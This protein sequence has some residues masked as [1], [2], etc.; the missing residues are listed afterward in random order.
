M[1]KCFTFATAVCIAGG[2]VFSALGDPYIETDGSQA[3]NTGYFV[4]PKTRV[5][6]DYAMLD[7][8]T[9]QQRVF[10]CLGNVVCQHYINGSRGYSFALQNSS[11]DWLTVRP[12][13]VQIFATADRRRF[14]LDVKN[15]LASFY[16]DG[17]LVT[18]RATKNVTNTANYPLGLFTTCNNAAFTSFADQRGKLRLYSFK[19]YEDDVLVMELLPYRDGSTYCLKDTVSGTLFPPTIGNPFTGGDLDEDDPDTVVIA[20]GYNVMTNGPRV[21][22]TKNVQVNTAGSGGIVKMNPYSGYTGWTRLACGTLWADNLTGGGVG[23]LGGSATLV[24]GPGTLRYDG[25]DG[26]VWSGTITNTTTKLESTVIDTQHDLTLEGKWGWET[27][28]FVKTGPGTLTL[29][30]TAGGNAELARDGTAIEGRHNYQTLNLRANGDAPTVGFGKLTVAEGTLVFGGGNWSLEKSVNGEGTPLLAVVGTKTV[31]PIDN[32]ANAQEKEATL[33][34]DAGTVW[35]RGWFGVGVK[36]GFSTTTPDFVPTSK[37]IINGGTTYITNQLVVGYNSNTI[38]EKD[39]QGKWIPFRTSPRVEV[40]GGTFRVWNQ[41]R[42]CDSPGTDCALFIDGGNLTV[43]HVLDTSGSHIRFASNLSGDPTLPRHADVTVCTNGVLDITAFFINNDRTNVTVNLNVLDGGRFRNNQMRLADTQGRTKNCEMNVL[44]DG[45]ILELRWGGYKDWIKADVTSVRI[46][47][48]GATLRANGCDVNVTDEIHVS[49]AAADTHPDEEAKGVTVSGASNYNSGFRFFLPQYWAGPTRI[50]TN[51]ICEMADT[52]AFPSG[53]DL[54]LDGTGRLVLTNGIAHAVNSFTLGTPNMSD[55]SAL[56]LSPGT[57]IQAGAFGVAGA[58]SLSL[59]L[60]AAAGVTNSLTAAGTYVLMSGPASAEDGLREIARRTAVANPADGTDY[61]LDVSVDGDTASL[62]V[63]VAPGPAAVATTKAWGN[64]QGGNWSEGANW[65]DGAEANGAGA[66]AAFT[67]EAEADG[68]AVTVD[69]AKTVGGLAFSTANA[70]ALSGS[71]L[72]LANGASPATVNVTAGGP[73]IANALS[74]VGSANLNT[75]GGTTLGVSGAVTGTGTL[76]ANAGG[77]GSG[78][79]TLGSALDGFNGRFTYKG[80]ITHVSSLA[81]A[82]A[83]PNALELGWGT[84]D[85]TGT[86]ET[87]A[88][89]TLNAGTIYSS[90]LWI[91][92]DL[93]LTSLGGVAGGLVKKGAGD[94]IFKGNGTFTFNNFQRDYGRSSFNDPQGIMPTGEPQDNALPSMLVAEGR[95][96]IGTTGDD[97][98]APHVT[99]PRV[100]QV[101]GRTVDWNSWANGI[102]ETSGEIVMNNGTLDAQYVWLGYYCGMPGSVDPEN[103]PHAK[104]T[105]NGGTIHA[106]EGV[107]SLRDWQGYQSVQ[108]ELVQNGGTIRSDKRVN[109]GLQISTNGATTAV[110]INDG[111][112]EAGE[113][114]YMGSASGTGP[115]TFT[116]NGGEVRC[117]Y[118]RMG[119]HAAAGRQELY[120]NGGTLYC[121]HLDHVGLANATAAGSAAVYFRG[122]VIKPGYRRNVAQGLTLGGTDGKNQFEAYVGAAG[123]IFDFTEWEKVGFDSGILEV[124]NKFLHDPECEGE[125]GGILLTGRNT[126]IVRNTSSGST[127]TGPFRTANGAILGV[128]NGWTDLLTKRFVIEASCGLRASGGVMGFKDVTFGTAGS[129][130]VITLDSV[131]GTQNAGVSASE[132]VAVLSPVTVSYHRNGGCCNTYGIQDGTYPVLYYKPDQE[133]NVPLEMFVANERFPEKSFSYVKEDVTSGNYAGWRVVKVTIAPTDVNAAVWTSVSAGGDWSEGANWNGAEPPNGTNAPAAFQPATAAAV[134]VN[135][136]A[137]PT[138]GQINLRGANAGTG[139]SFTGGAINLNHED[140]R[141]APGF[142]VESGTHVIANDLT[143]DDTYYRSNET[144]ANGGNTGAVGIYPTNG[145]R[146]TV[147]GTVTMD[148]SRPLRVN[149][150]TSGGGTTVFS[151]RIAQGAGVWV[152]SGKLE[153]DDVSTLDGKMLTVGAGTFHYTGPTATTTMKLTTNPNNNNN[154]ASILRIDGD[155]TVAG[156]FNTVTGGVMKTGPGTLTIAPGGTATTTI[157]RNGRNTSWNSTGADWYWPANGDPSTKQGSGSLCIDEGEVRLAGPNAQFYISNSG[158]MLDCFIG[159]NDRGWCYTTNYAA[160]TILSGTVRGPWLYLGHTFNHG[161]DANGH[162]IPTYSVYNQYGGN[163]TL[164]AFCFCY[165]LSD[166]D[167]ACQATANLYDGTLTDLGVMRFGQ[168]YNKTGI[169]PPHATFNVYGGTYNHTDTSG[170][171]GTR[172]GYLGDKAGGQKTLN[173]ACDATLNMYGGNYNEI[174]LVHMGCNAS[175]SHLNL[176]GGVLK[177]ENIILDTS[178]STSYCFFSGGSAYIFW[179][180]GVFAPVGTAAANRTLT[181]LTEVLVSTNGAVVTTA[182]LAG[183]T[184]TVAQP[185][186]HDPDLEEADGGFVKKGAKPLALTGANTYTG[187][188]VVEAGTL[189]IPVGADASALP[190]NSAIVVAEGATLS[191]ASGTAA[192]VGGLRFDM[193]TQYGTLAGFAPAAQGTLYVDGVDETPRKGLVLPVTVTDAQVKHNLSRWPVVIDGEVDEKVCGRVRDNTIVLDSRGGLVFTIR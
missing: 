146:V 193:G 45:G 163:V 92:N 170:T 82:S 133:A 62:K 191:M 156:Q 14:V 27:G 51:G 8:Q 120:L 121:R 139:Y 101:G 1:K 162:L 64:A 69:A 161:K 118:F 2:M 107:E 150:P 80:G 75:A 36:N 131:A 35:F 52:A 21:V 6:V 72:T 16:T 47:T 39:A 13:N 175:T 141:I 9:V 3:V 46:G 96:V 137:A 105:M 145:A 192:R 79:V 73:T 77:V 50:T 179:N 87:I 116:L 30:N 91:E 169:N 143:T 122:G 128:D 70:Y 33:R 58:S 148:P 29:K 173:R 129:T 154:L 66:V 63:T 144:D 20:P 136:D 86:G 78:Q 114:I 109:F 126:V 88:G 140:F 98:D 151:G 117:D 17:V 61:V 104:L 10:G 76:T 158:T 93:T 59:H 84:L 23:A 108:A 123:A 32:A 31:E 94:L 99:T 85:Y 7:L 152:N 97:A 81:F 183:D 56:W 142:I 160:L 38:T 125:D 190:A 130:N 119:N 155:L 67:T 112:F 41:L 178:T 149:T 103:L 60:R 15:K 25:P 90:V 65:T 74:F 37:L 165:D 172:M 181:G 22:G 111:L 177:A 12:D 102:C 40:H 95:L 110:T 115:G 189:S 187:D 48:R 167:T 182:E 44:V 19:I 168:T 147:T 184:Y 164:S 18:S 188:T 159:A 28:G 171:K 43:R 5:E 34:V 89:L 54:T 134:P 176:H 124:R 42:M 26:G 57:S 185:L 135:V 24:L 166:Y 127:F 4:K 157:G 106:T 174:E 53:T 180:G 138:V 11:G 71:A 55:V 113:H 49:F 186:L 153:M 68:T 100:F 132:H 83:R